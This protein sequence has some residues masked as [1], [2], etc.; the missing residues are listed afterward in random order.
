MNKVILVGNLTKDPELSTTSS[1]VPYCRFSLAVTRRFA[2]AEGN[3][4]TDFFNI[5]VWRA[6]A[7]NCHK[8]LHKGSK[9][10]VIGSLQTRSYEDKDGNKKYVTDIIADEVEFLS[11]KPSSSE[12]DFENESSEKSEQ[13]ASKPKKGELKPIVDDDLPF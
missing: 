6:Q 12:D 5:T 10:G 11:N 9:A 7:E 8:Y 13:G 4:E 1:G 2:N 3:R